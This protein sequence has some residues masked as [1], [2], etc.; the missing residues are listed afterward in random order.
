MRYTETIQSGGVFRFS[1]SQTGKYLI[2][3]EASAPVVLRGDSLRNT[4]IERGDT[5]DIRDFTDLEL[6]N[7][8]QEPLLIDFQ[9]V[10]IAIQTRAQKVNVENQLSVSGID[11]PVTIGL[12]P[13]VTIANFPD[14][15]KTEQ[16]STQLAPLLN[17]TL[18]NQAATIPANDKRKA[19]LI[20][21]DETN[22]G[23]VVIA[24]FLR[25]LAGGIA[26]IPAINELTVSGVSGDK[27]Y[28][29]EVVS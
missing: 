23:V 20:Q 17:L 7:Y 4:E 15:L 1:A 9:I 3:R 16:E 21:A 18:S 19:V 13:D 14:T 6:V 10:D 26:T 27:V 22:Q 25:L 24:G 28:C 2:I 8:R 12:M 29:G 5:V 11:E